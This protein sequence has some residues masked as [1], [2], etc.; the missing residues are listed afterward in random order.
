VRRTRLGGLRGLR[1]RSLALVFV[2]IAVGMYA[3]HVARWRPLAVVGDMPHDGYPRVTGVVHVHTTLSDGAATPE[4]VI[5]AARAAGLGFVVITDHNTLDAKRWEGYHDG[6]LVI[7]GTEVS[8]TAGHVLGLGITDPEFRFSGDAADALDDIETLHGAAF[9]AHPTSAR[10]DFRWTGWD[11]PGG[12]GIEVLNGDSQWRS[13]GWLRLART[14]ALYP[15]NHEYALLGSLTAPTDALAR[16]D[17]L[18]ARRPAA[19]I[20]GADAHGQIPVRK[21]RAVRFP[22]YESLFRL[23]RN[24]VLLSRPLTGDAAVDAPAIVRALAVGRSFVALDGLAA[25]DAFSFT[26]AERGE[27]STHPWSMG[28]VVPPEPGLRLRAG[29]RLPAH[30]R[31][32]LLRNGETL[33]EAEGRIDVEA[34]GPGVYRVEVGVPGWPVPWVISNPISVYAAREAKARAQAALPPPPPSVP[35]ATRTLDD[36]EAPAGTTF[37]PEFDPSSSMTADVL[38]PGAGPDGSRAARMEFR[39]GAPGPGRPY[40]WCALV[41]RETRDLSGGH[42][43]VFSVRGDREYRVWVQVR[44]ANPAAP[45]GTEWWFASVRTEREWRRVALPFA[46]LRTLEAKT[47]GRLDLDKVRQLVFVIDQGADKPGTRGTVWIDDLGL[48]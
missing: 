14:L 39:L 42:G 32:R 25:A 30:A 31:V 29:G 20:A 19:G 8:T 9:A 18:L 43:L 41:S 45:D 22:S 21:D 10:P 4:E 1:A 38:T 7:V 34:P 47:D 48:Y 17:A 2:A 40:V 5:A 26:V 12:W 23:A 11:L 33:T 13:A 44:D 46:R 35:E 6:V 36:F 16:W 15:L 3:I 37:H 28:D 27:T 24:H